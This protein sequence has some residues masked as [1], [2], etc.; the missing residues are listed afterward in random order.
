MEMHDLVNNCLF[1]VDFKM[2]TF[3]SRCA[4]EYLMCTMKKPLKFLTKQLSELIEDTNSILISLCE[5][6]LQN[7]S[8]ERLKSKWLKNDWNLFLVSSQNN[9]SYKTR[10]VSKERLLFL[11]FFLSGKYDKWFCFVEH[12]LPRQPTW[13]GP[14]S[15]Q[16]TIKLNYTF[17]G[18]KLSNEISE[19]SFHQSPNL[20]TTRVMRQEK[21]N[22]A[23]AD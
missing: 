2:K 12:H 13:T 20:F 3:S 5:R 22:H 4:K 19:L 7:L 23:R 18:C 21:R 6:N 16:N 11:F 15:D 1:G 14:S 10:N 9:H 17:V 8:M